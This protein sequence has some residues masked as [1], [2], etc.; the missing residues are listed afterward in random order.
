MRRKTCRRHVTSN[1]YTG[2]GR[3]DSGALK[4]RGPHHCGVTR[5]LPTAPRRL[6]YAGV[7]ACAAVILYASVLEPG[8]GAPTTLFGVGTT[9]YLHFVAYAGLAGA[10]GYARLSADAR[11]VAAA[12]GIATLFGVAVELLQGTLS[13]RTMSGLD[14]V[15]NAA[16]AVVGALLWRVIAL[17]FGRN[18]PL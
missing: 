16:G 11:T 10:V 7:V 18:R 1:G 6:R 17:W 15:V 13:Y 8:H 5:S 3:A 2:G 12:A 14:V 4:S 9:V